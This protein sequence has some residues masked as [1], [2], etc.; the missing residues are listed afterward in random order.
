MTVSSLF[1]TSPIDGAG[2]ECLDWWEGYR[3][4]LPMPGLCFSF[5]RKSGD[6]FFALNFV[7]WHFVHCGIPEFG[8]NCDYISFKKKKKIKLNLTVF[9]HIFE[10][11]QTQ[12]MTQIT[13]IYRRFVWSI[14]ANCACHHCQPMFRNGSCSRRRHVFLPF[15]V[16][17]FLFLFFWRTVIRSPGFFGYRVRFSTV[18]IV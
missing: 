1:L 17:F 12:R 5:F 18:K 11:V 15:Y 6:T 8:K 7:D 9:C 4:G 13:Q 3:R 14:L 2:D 10:T 16:L